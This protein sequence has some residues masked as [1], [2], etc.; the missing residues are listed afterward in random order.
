MATYQYRCDR[1]GLV[2]TSRSIGTAPADLCCPACGDPARR[3]FTV[4]LLRHPDRRA[5]SLIDR[6]EKTRE[7]PAV[8]T[9][10]PPPRPSRPARPRPAASPAQLRLPRP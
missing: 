8:V 6:T 10:L 9:S 5:M 4:P 3:V 2:E 1:D 7:A